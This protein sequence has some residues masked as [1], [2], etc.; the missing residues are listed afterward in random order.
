MITA[1]EARELVRECKEKDKN[2]KEK[3]IFSIIESYAKQGYNKITS[4]S[5][6]SMTVRT[7]RL[8]GFKVIK[9]IDCW[10]YACFYHEISWKE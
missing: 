5:L 9:Y 3:E 10:D 4:S 7:L 2:K 1:K 6:S 8:K